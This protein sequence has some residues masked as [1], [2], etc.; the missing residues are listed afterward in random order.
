MEPVAD[1]NQDH[2]DV[3]G[4]GHEHLPQ[5]LHLLLFLGGILHPGQLGNALHQVGHHRA[6]ELGDLLVGGTGVLDTVVEQG[7]DDGVGVQLQ[8]GHDLGHRQ[9]MGDIG[10]SV[11]TQLPG[12]GIVRIGERAEQALGIQCRI[13]GFNLVLKS[14]ITLQDGV[15]T[16]HLLSK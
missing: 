11:L 3:L 13:I 15:H 1:F 12:V 16:G 9:G 5:V 10:R 6:E 14:L 8:L 4:H 7:G 2:P